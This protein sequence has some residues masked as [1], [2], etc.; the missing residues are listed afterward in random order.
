[1]LNGG[2]ESTRWYAFDI[3]RFRDTFPANHWYEPT[4]A[5]VDIMRDMSA[6][7]TF[8][9][10]SVDPAS[11]QCVNCNTGKQCLG[12]VLLTPLGSVEHISGQL[13]KRLEKDKEYEVSFWLKGTARACS[14]TPSGLGVVLHSDSISISGERRWGDRVNRP[15]PDYLNLFEKLPLYADYEADYPPTDTTWRRFSFRY[16]ALGGER[17]LT[18]GRFAY[19][20][21]GSSPSHGEV[22]RYLRKVNKK[23]YKD[24]VMRLTLRNKLGLFYVDPARSCIDEGSSFYL[25]DDVSVVLV[26]DSSRL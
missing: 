15:S 4:A 22:V 19:G 14:V 2:F 25:L 20:K 13:S 9:V 18:F 24:R 23:P 5:T 10:F 17:F 12:I 6:C 3:R 21:D 1:M 26:V 11:R 8:H 16:V 7:D